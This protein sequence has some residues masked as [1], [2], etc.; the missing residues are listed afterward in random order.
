MLVISTLNF[1]LGNNHCCFIEAKTFK[2]ERRTLLSMKSL[3]RK[4]NLKVRGSS[5]DGKK[6]YVD[7]NNFGGNKIKKIML[8]ICLMKNLMK[9][10]IC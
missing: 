8:I 2:N 5:Y 1:I 9:S 4:E 6:N 7:Y 10:L 3:E